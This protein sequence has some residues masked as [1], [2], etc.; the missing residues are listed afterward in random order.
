MI[1]EYPVEINCYTKKDAPYVYTE[2]AE[3]YAQ[4]RSYLEPRKAGTIA[5]FAGEPLQHGITANEWLDAGYVIK[6]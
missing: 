4:K 5:C 2:Y 3:Q 6:R 1:K